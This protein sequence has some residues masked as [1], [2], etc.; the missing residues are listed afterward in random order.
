VA[1]RLGEKEIAID[2]YLHV[3]ESWTPADSAF[4][5]YV[6][7][8]HEALKRLGGENAPRIKLGTQ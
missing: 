5:P 4:Q 3:T 8:S 2:G 7:A 6:K 1:E